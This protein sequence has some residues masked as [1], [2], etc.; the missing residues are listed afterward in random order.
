MR[1][2]LFLFVGILI[3][4][5]AEEMPLQPIT[6][7]G[8][9]VGEKLCLPFFAFTTSSGTERTVFWYKTLEGKIDRSSVKKE[10]IKVEIVEESKVPTYEYEVVNEQDGARIRL[11]KTEFGKAQGC[12]PPQE[13]TKTAQ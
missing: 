10:N 3:V 9:I 4:A 7:P 6:R 11:S 5:S 8:G 1:K 2:I 13:V 12:L